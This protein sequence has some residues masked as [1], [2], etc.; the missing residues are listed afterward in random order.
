MALDGSTLD[1]LHENR[2]R[3]GACRAQGAHGLHAAGRRAAPRARRARSASPRR[4]SSGST[5]RRGPRRIRAS[6][7]VSRLNR[8]EYANA[9]RDL[10][11][12]DAG[13]IVATLPPD[14]AIQGFDNIAAALTVSPTLIE[15]YVN[16]ALKIS[17]AAVGDRSQGPTQVSYDAPGGSQAAHVDGLPLGTRGGFAL[18]AQLSARCGLRDPRAGARPRRA[19]GTTLLRTAAHRHHA[20]RRAARRRRPGRNP[21]ARWPADRIR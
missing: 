7:R 6:R 20:R 17:R 13:A 19:G 2:R 12:Y 11:A 3:L 18:H 5:P 16:A 15:S 10:S 1:A 8:A 14:D 21:S 4:S 9:V